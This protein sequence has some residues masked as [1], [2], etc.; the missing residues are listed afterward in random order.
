[1]PATDFIPPK[2]ADLSAWATNFSTVITAS[3]ATYGLV[4]GQATTFATLKTAF[5]SALATATNPGTRTPA[6]I[7]AKD[8]ARSA[9]VA[10]ARVLARIAQGTPGITPTQLSNAGL[11][12]RNTVPTPIPAPTT[13][14]VLGLERNLSQ[15]LV[16]RMRDESTPTSR[17]KPFGAVAAQV[18]ASVGVAPPA[19]P[20]DG[21]FKGPASRIPFQVDFDSA[22][23][24][25]TAYIY[26]RWVTAKG[27]TGPWSDVLAVTVTA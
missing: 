25:K 14:P 22:D 7:A 8:S 13:K 3:P 4:A 9:M 27:L 23:V 20:L 24:G 15:A 16:L 12:V 19:T 26:A 10:N 1:M 2:D 6:A 17:A 18:Y 5:V 21:T 11:T